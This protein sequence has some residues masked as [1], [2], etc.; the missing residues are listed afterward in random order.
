LHDS[1][2]RIGRQLKRR[3]LPSP[4]GRCLTPT[5]RGRYGEESQEGEEGS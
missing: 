4:A 2:T 5:Q 3:W 1:R